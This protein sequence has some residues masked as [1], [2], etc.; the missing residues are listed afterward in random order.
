MQLSYREA[1]AEVFDDLDEA[2]LWAR[3]AWE[4]AARADPAR[5]K[6]ARAA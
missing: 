5:K 6:K 2:A 4:A 3:R 1:P